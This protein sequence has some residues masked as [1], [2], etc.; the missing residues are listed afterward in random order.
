MKKLLRLPLL[1]EVSRYAPTID[2]SDV[3]AFVDLKV[4]SVL[5]ACVEQEG[6]RVSQDHPGPTSDREAEL[7]RRLQ[8]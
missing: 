5:L 7:G 1:A 2:A 6:D 3:I 4:S 8:R